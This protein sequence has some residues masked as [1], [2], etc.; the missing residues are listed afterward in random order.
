MVS[1]KQNKA[2]K[3]GVE[4]YQ[5]IKKSGK[6]N[7]RNISGQA[8]WLCKVAIYLQEYHQEIYLEIVAKINELA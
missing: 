1:N 7:N 5:I 2:I 6:A 3:F 8:D 4:M